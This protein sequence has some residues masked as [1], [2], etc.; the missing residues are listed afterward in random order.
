[1]IAFLS[2]LHS[3]LEA[4][5]TV[6]ARIEGMGCERIFVL[7]DFVGYSCHPNEVIDLCLKHKAEGIRGNHDEAV[8]TG[9]TSY[10]NEMAAKAVLWTQKN[11]SPSSL[12]FLRSLPVKRHVE[13]FQKKCLLVHGSPS[14][15][16][17][18][19]VYPDYP[20]YA[21]LNF[22]GDAHVLGMGH[23]HIAF[24][25]I[26]KEKIVFNP[27]SVGQPRDRNPHA[28]FALFDG[29]RIMHERLTYEIEKEADAILSCGLPVFLAER[30]FYGI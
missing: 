22:L 5:R 29:K 25:K 30:L 27:G 20:D 23:T 8:I 2:D 24:S 21:F 10:F 9:D 14:E 28:S 11:L 4:T 6:F 13:V 12:A 7:G 16:L 3:N 18:E 26:L 1:M 15:P 19:Y 17:D